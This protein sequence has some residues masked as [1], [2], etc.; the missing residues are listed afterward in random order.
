MKPLDE[1]KVP[2]LKEVTVALFDMGGTL[3]PNPFYL[4]LLRHQEK[5]RE[6]S[7]TLLAN[8]L[9][10][11]DPKWGSQLAENLRDKW[12]EFV[13]NW[14]ASDAVNDREHFSHFLQEQYIIAEA[15]RRTHRFEYADAAVL[16]PILLAAY[17]C[18]V[19]ELC[20]TWKANSF[21]QAVGRF[22]SRLR[23]SGVYLAV[24]SNERSF[25]PDALLHW[26][27]LREYFHSIKASET[28]GFCKPHEK[29]L[30]SFLEMPEVSARR[31]LGGST[32]M[33]GDRYEH[34]LAPAK[35]K[36]L[37]TILVRDS[38]CFEEVPFP[39][40]KWQDPANC[41]QSDLVVE[42]LL[43]LADRWPTG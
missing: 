17:R 2:W 32:V 9:R 13:L 34:D 25:G 23:E 21:F 24:L 4:I 15:V 42:T 26:V 38:S 31:E 18:V 3:C 28:I 1:R 35:A 22:L 7:Q 36:G 43:E 10:Q 11:A 5:L 16:A 40:G 29:A 41:A 20:L 12:S 30:E 14:V 6:L 39:T 37:K 19:T 33:I 27:G 8:S